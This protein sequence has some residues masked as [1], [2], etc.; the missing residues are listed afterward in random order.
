MKRAVIILSLL[1][2]GW[3]S[4][5]SGAADLT[6]IDR[7]IAK[8]PKYESEPYYALIVIGPKAEK[9]IWLVM[10]GE[11]VYVDRN[12]NGDLTEP[13]ERVAL[14]SKRT[15]EEPSVY[16]GTN[17][18]ELGEVA[19]VSLRLDFQVRDK[20]FIPQ[21]EF[22][23]TIFKDHQEKGWEFATLRR[24]GKNG[25]MVEMP[26]TFCRRP[27][28]AQ[29]CHFAG[30]LTFALQSKQD[31]L[32]RNSDKNTFR[33]VI[34]TPGL[35]A[36]TSDDSVFANLT[37]AEVPAHVHPVADFEFPHKDAKQSAIK[38]QVVLEKRC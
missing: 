15:Y 27:Q 14:K 26:V 17:S 4:P 9:R 3:A 36:R 18:F 11:V 35:P 19:G 37:I 7:S 1:W 21:T 38:L 33:V 22:D 28:D 8:E 31:S 13:N 29:L 5:P 12:G 20:D 24:Q 25:N 6:K 32:V 2:L 30:P 10:D 16:K 34:G 23:K